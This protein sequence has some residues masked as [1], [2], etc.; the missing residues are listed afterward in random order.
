VNKHLDRK[1][2]TSCLSMRERAEEKGEL[3]GLAFLYGS[4][5]MQQ[6]LQL[7]LT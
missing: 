5:H 7:S 3:T 6:I 4:G 1:A 2:Q